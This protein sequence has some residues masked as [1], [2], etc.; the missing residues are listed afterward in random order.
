ML[1]APLKTSTMFFM[2]KANAWPPGRVS[3][4]AAR[5]NDESVKTQRFTSNG[6][7]PTRQLRRGI[8]PRPY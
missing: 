3:A 5:H 7:A 8:K 4:M 6:G 1:Q 2:F